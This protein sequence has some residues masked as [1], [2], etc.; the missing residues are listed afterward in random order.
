MVKITKANGDV[1]ELTVDEAQVLMGDN[2]KV[3]VK[4]QTKVLK[5]TRK[6]VLKWTRWSPEEDKIIKS[7]HKIKVMK[8][9]LPGRT[10]MAI[11]SRIK[12]LRGQGNKIK[13]VITRSRNK[14]KHQVKPTD[15][16][17]KM[18]KQIAIILKDLRKQHP[19][20]DITD[21]RKKAF[22]IYKENKP[23]LIGIY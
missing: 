1:W 6:V 14:Q 11:R 5:N 12:T 20:A 22:Q 17:I 10:L 18:M 13:L 9:L 15:G 21:L 4:E 7:N 16:R 2:T 19:Y 3:L 8:K 23:K